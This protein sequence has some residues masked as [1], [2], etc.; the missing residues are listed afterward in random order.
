MLEFLRLD[1]DESKDMIG[2]KDEGVRKLKGI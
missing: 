2:N 1:E